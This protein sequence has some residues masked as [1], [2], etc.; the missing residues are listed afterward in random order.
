M[1]KQFDPNAAALSGSGIFGLPH[2]LDE[3]TLVYLPVP[4]EATTSYGGG[5]SEGP[6]AILKASYQVDLFDLEVF[7]PY[8]AGLFLLKESEEIKRWNSEAKDL[9]SKVIEAGGDIA[10]SE[11]LMHALKRV[12]ELGLKLNKN[13]FEETRRLLNV[14]KMVCVLGGDHSAPFGAIQAVAEKYEH[15]GIL[16]FDAHS[17]TRKSFEGFTWSHASI[18]YNV[19]VGVRDFCEEELNYCQT[20]KNRVHTYFDDHLAAR[21]FNGTCWNEISEEIVSSLPKDVW[22]S[23]DIDGLDPCLCPHTGTPVPGGLSFNEAVCIVKSLVKSGRRIIGF[24]LDEVS[25]S[26]DHN[27]EWD[28]NVGARLLYRLTSWTLASQ[29]KAKWHIK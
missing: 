26:Q 12:N 15:F 5:T 3:A 17:D 14:Q 2:T 27:N 25:P 6:S 13:V 29:G 4:W 7:R 9:A 8:E 10:D 16:H 20:K 18:M 24:D 21:K 19:Q 22:I 11:D 28:A 23:F 1:T